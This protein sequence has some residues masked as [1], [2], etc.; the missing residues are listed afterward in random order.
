MKPSQ[1]L[2]QIVLICGPMTGYPDFNRPAFNTVAAEL[3]QKG[4]IVFNPATLPD[5]WTHDQYME[6]TLQWVEE[7]DRFYFLRGWERSKGA[8][9]EFDR[10][11]NR[12]L[13]L[14]AVPAIQFQSMGA[15]IAAMNRCRL[16]RCSLTQCKGDHHE[17]I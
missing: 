11:C 3:R 4:F 10:I 14:P 8:V 16:L 5:G 17:Q 7:A 9:M 2:S 1:H 6:T 12:F 13:S 15:F